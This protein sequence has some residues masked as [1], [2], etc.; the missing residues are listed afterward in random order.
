MANFTVAALLTAQQIL[1]KKYTQPEMRMKPSPALELLLKNAPAFIQDV[2]TVRTREDRPTELHLMA[3][4]KRTSGT[5]RTHNHTGTLDDTFKVTPTWV[6]KSDVTSISLKLLDKNLFSFSEVLANKLEQ[7]MMN[8][9]EDYETAAVAYM[10]AQRS[11]VSAA[12][13]GCTFNATNDVIDIA[14]ANKARFYQILKSAFRQNKHS[15]QLDIIADPLMSMTAEDLR[16]QGAGNDSNDAFQFGGMR[17]VESIELADANYANGLVL[18]MPTGTVGA[19]QWIPK[20]NRAGFG[21]Y[22]SYVGGFGT[23]N[24]PWGLGLQFA[25]HGYAQRADTS[26]TNG[27]KQ[28]VQ[29]EFEVSLDMSFNKAPINV[30]NESPIFQAGQLAV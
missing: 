30:A 8:I 20:Q 28:D 7:C 10:Q 1:D 17:I 13:K 9:V 6:S 18:A 3:R 4:T 29:M 27:D 16:A 11:Q 22:N 23:I 14:A 5:G 12:L 21:D 26:A 15:T 25:L 19:M 2:N 24:D